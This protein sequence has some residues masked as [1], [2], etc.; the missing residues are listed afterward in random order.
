MGRKT[1]VLIDLKKYGEMWED[2]Y[3]ALVA[4]SRAN[5]PR[6]SIEVVKRRLQK[7]GKLNG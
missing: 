4:Q 5:E 2:F 6:E 1:A 3:D 7:Q